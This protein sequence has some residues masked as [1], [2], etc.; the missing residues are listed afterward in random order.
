MK[1]TQ[2]LKLML[3][4]LMATVSTSALAY[5]GDVFTSKNLVCKELAGNKAQV[6]GYA[7]VPSNGMTVVI[8]D[9][10]L[11]GNDND[12]PL[13]VSSLSDDWF[14]G[15][16]I[17]WV[18]DNVIQQQGTNRPALTGYTFALKIEASALESLK[19]NQIQ[20]LNGNITQFIVTTTA[21]LKGVPAYAFAHVPMQ[22]VD[23]TDSDEYKELAKQIEDY[24][25]LLATQSLEDK[26]ACVVENG[27]YQ[28]P[29]EK[30]KGFK[31]YNL[32]VN[33]QGNQIDQS[34]AD[35]KRSV[36]LDTTVEGTADAYNTD[37]KINYPL[38]VVSANGSV[39]A[40]GGALA[41]ERSNG[42]LVRNS[43]ANGQVVVIAQPLKDGDAAYECWGSYTVKGLNTLVSEAKAKYETL[44]GLCNTIGSEQVYLGL[45]DN[46]QAAGNLVTKLAALKAMFDEVRDA[47]TDAGYEVTAAVAAGSDATLTNDFQKAAYAAI[48]PAMLEAGFPNLKHPKA[49]ASQMTTS[50][51]SPKK[52]YEPTIALRQLYD[53]PSG[54]LLF[55]GASGNFNWIKPVVIENGKLKVNNDDCQAIVNPDGSKVTPVADDANGTLT[56]NNEI[57]ATPY[58]AEGTY[59]LKGFAKPSFETVN[60]AYSAALNAKAD[61]DKAIE[62]F[63]AYTDEEGETYNKAELGGDDCTGGLV[64]E[65]LQAW[66]D[67]EQDKKDYEEAAAADLD[68]LKEDLEDLAET[69][70]PETDP[71]KFLN[72][73]V[74]TKVQIDNNKMEYFGE[75]AFVNC[76]GVETADW[77]AGTTSFTFPAT[78]ATIGAYAFKGT[79]INAKLGTCSTNLQKIGDYAFQDT[80]TEYVN[81]KNATQ[82][83]DVD[84]DGN[85]LTGDDIMIGKGVWNNTPLISI[86]LNNTGLTNMPDG[87]AEKI[88]RENTLVDG[89]EAEGFYVQANTTLTSVGLPV[90]LKKIADNQFI[91]CLSLGYNKTAGTNATLTVPGTVTSIGEAA[92]RGTAYKEI[93][94]TALTE[95]DYVGDLAFANNSALESVSFAAEAPFENLEGSTFECDNNLSEIELNDD[96]ECLPAG[97]FKGTA[98][99]KLDLSKTQLTVLNNLFEATATEPNTT[100]VELTLPETLLDKDNYTVLRPGLKV[101]ADKALSQLKAL[102]GTKQDD[103]SY[104]M[105]IPS[106]VELM[107]SYVFQNDKALEYVDII[108]SK[109]T[110]LGEGTFN[111]TDALKEV[112]FVTLNRIDK[113]IETYDALPTIDDANYCDES[114]DIDL[115]NKF[116][117]VEGIVF[118]KVGRNPVPTVY[119][120]KESYD[121]LIVD[122]G[123]NAPMY[124]QHYTTLAKVEQ[125]IALAGP[126]DINGTQSYAITYFNPYYGTWIPMKAADQ[127]G[128][129]VKVWTAYQDGDVI[130]AYGAKHNNN[131]YKIPAA[132]EAKDSKYFPSAARMMEGEIDPVNNAQIDNPTAG[133]GEVE[134][135]ETVIEGSDNSYNYVIPEQNDM[136]KFAQQTTDGTYV[137]QSEQYYA[138]GSAVVIITSDKNTPVKFEQHSTKNTKYQSTLDYKNELKVTGIPVSTTDDDDI[139]KFTIY[140]SKWTFYQDVRDPIPALKTV[141]PMSAY[142]GTAYPDLTREIVFLD[143][144]YTS[145]DEVKQYVQ[146]MKESGDIYN[147]RGMK[148]TTPVKGQIYIQNGK[149]FI[150]K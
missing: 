46:Q 142:Q 14:L 110:K 123:I 128:A 117:F 111:S 124:E 93:D 102:K 92:F 108:D 98:I 109:L 105:I 32:L 43:R 96:I 137:F 73:E 16:Y 61:A 39:S 149:K 1:K 106:S 31:V 54:A 75:A 24:E 140:N 41:R 55:I 126:A 48:M 148:V 87:L 145:I 132:G 131:F 67:A 58:Y 141:F 99:E 72:N 83:T 125:T 88:R 63:V 150:Q 50:G 15:G 115:T 5:V 133:G 91:W 3:L 76:I 13:Y 30:Y 38:M 44:K 135:I 22:T 103:G 107:G 12:K 27:V 129:N 35:A 28:G 2:S 33:S 120:T 49:G 113:T 74:L 122:R 65:A 11:N 146:K 90:G 53:I 7:A 71:S 17:A 114:I 69:E 147:M 80:E 143:G 56:L 84:E 8:P 59:D 119:V 116:S 144:E 79:H 23:N 104:R 10:V 95:L 89:C 100:L 64:A 77:T 36:I 138:P 70:I 40:A 62:D 134:E 45:L 51:T 6:L 37:G 9:Q 26:L 52:V 21:G 97:I 136:D 86:A 60:S 47:W 130:Y 29:V 42:E 34:S 82:I 139:Y 127:D 85:L 4:G 78:T 94:L 118:G 101:I 81:L 121:E 20:P 19:T 66:N 68:D 112:K 18:R 25:T 57:I